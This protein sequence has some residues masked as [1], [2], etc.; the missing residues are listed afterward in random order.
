M[1]AETL[2][3]RQ[4]PEAQPDEKVKRA[5]RKVH[6][7][8]YQMQA[9]AFSLLQTLSQRQDPEQ[10]V[11]RVLKKLSEA[12]PSFPFV[13]KA[14]VEEASTLER[15]K[16]AATE[17]LR[18]AEPVEMG[19]GIFRPEAKDVEARVEVVM[20]PTLQLASKGSVEA[21]M[22]YFRSRFQQ[23]K[24]LL[25]QRLDLRDAATIRESLEGRAGAKVKFV[26][27]VA[28]KVSRGKRFF[29]RVD[30]LEAEAQVLV[31]DSNPMLVDKARNLL[32]DQVVGVVGVKTGNGLV[33]AEDLIL[34][35]VPQRRPGFSPE[36]VNAVLISDLHVGSKVF[37]GKLFQAFLGWLRGGGGG[38]RERELAGKVKYLLVAGDLVDGIGVYPQQ[39]EELEI[40]DV[41]RQY[42]AAAALLEQVPDHIVIIVIPGNHDAV[43]KALP[44][45]ALSKKYAEALYEK[46]GSQLVSLGNPAQVRLHGV[47][48]LLHHGRSLEDVLVSMPN[49]S[50]RN[51]AKAMLGLLKGRHLSPVYGQRTPIAPETRD[52]MVVDRV[53]DVYHAGHIHV[54]DQTYYRG[55]RLINSGCWQK[56]TLYQQRLGLTP[57][58]G[59]AAVVNLKTLALTVMD[60]SRM[61]GAP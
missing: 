10:I 55:V 47:E 14:M 41:C 7:A 34:P 31:Q 33:V 56:Q 32:L 49:V 20:D 16:R 38:R 39:E 2:G 24:R 51:P 35:D 36:E 13:S 37:E 58:P 5:L 53:P 61:L 8:G 19:K 12:P 43:R 52:W 27:M 60:F 44:Q 9:E 17:G 18:E 59:V 15:E 11:D 22:E 40:Q 54:F 57:T 48:F 29:L 28:E 30:D 50:H 45:P 3:Y 23:L 6:E 26:G 4:T 42:E 21:F 46:C 1:E 25:R